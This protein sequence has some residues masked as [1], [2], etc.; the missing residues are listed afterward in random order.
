MNNLYYEDLEEVAIKIYN[1]CSDLDYK[2]YEE[3]KEREIKDITDALYQ[4]KA[5][6][7]NEYNSD[8]WR[9]FYN[10]LKSIN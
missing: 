1:N 4:I 6:A 9:T 8:Y 5:I 10:A 2:D 7:E 3:L